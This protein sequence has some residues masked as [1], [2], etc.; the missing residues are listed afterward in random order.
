M[1]GQKSPKQAVAELKQQA[2]QILAQP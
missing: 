2:T 1:A